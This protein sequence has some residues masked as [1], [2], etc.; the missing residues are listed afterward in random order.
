M[1]D[2]YAKADLLSVDD[3]QRRCPTKSMSVAGVPETVKE[4]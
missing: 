3:G 4:T 1:G 2:M